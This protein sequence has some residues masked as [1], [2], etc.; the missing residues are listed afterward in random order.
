MRHFHVGFAGL[1][2]RTDGGRGG[3]EDVDLVVLDHLPEAAGVG[4]GGH[5]FEH[6][7]GAAAGERA[8]GDVG[9]AGDPADVGG[10]PEHI[11]GLQVEGPLHGQ[12]GVQ[13]IAAGG[14]L[15][16]LRL[17]GGT[18]GVEQEQRMLGIDP[19][20]FADIGLI[21]HHVIATRGR[22]LPP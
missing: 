13:Q 17:A 15:H 7:L 11:V 2:Q 20:R 14:V 12:D 10:T 19:F 5:A 6:D 16:A 18:G 22:G 1:D 4:E 3:V 8:V 21:R 9:V